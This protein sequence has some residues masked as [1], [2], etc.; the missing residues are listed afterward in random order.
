M[1]S[2]AW[3][4]D[5]DGTNSP[6]T[7]KAKRSLISVF[8]EVPVCTLFATL[9]SPCAVL[10][11]KS[12]SQ[13]YFLLQ[14]PYPV[15]SDFVRP[16]RTTRAYYT[17]LVPHPRTVPLQAS[18]DLGSQSS[19]LLSSPPLCSLSALLP[20]SSGQVTPSGGNR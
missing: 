2:E 18:G 19:L 11:R 4:V 15:R 5:P 8:L 16:L 13:Y 6:S 14:Q 7:L 12:I 10:T 9:S 20:A 1:S 3:I 17:G